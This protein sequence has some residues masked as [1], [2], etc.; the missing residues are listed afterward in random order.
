MEIEEKQLSRNSFV[1]LLILT[2][3]MLA[4]CGGDQSPTGSQPQST[5]L[6]ATATVGA[7]VAG[8][9]EPTAT[10]VATDAAPTTPAQQTGG[11]MSIGLDMTNVKPC[12]LLTK[13]EVEAL[14]GPSETPPNETISII[15]DVG[16]TFFVGWDESNHFLQVNIYP[17]VYWLDIEMR[18]IEA[19]GPVIS[20]A[21]LG[22]KAVTYPITTFDGKE[23]Q[24][25]TVLLEKKA[26]VSVV[27]TP[28]DVEKAKEVMVKI[29]ERLPK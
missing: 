22:D 14:M 28:R 15:G 25:L 13:E 1:S 9:A 27:I 4:G 3:A 20:V 24:E 5:G 17:P 23:R 16:C 26:A 8:D 7:P 19:D 18:N 12:S 21:G 2:V 10:S 6:S 29:L 11:G